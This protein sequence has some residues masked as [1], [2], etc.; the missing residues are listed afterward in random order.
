MALYRHPFPHEQTD[1]EILS[2]PKLRSQAI[3]K[4]RT[5][6]CKKTPPSS[7][8]KLTRETLPLIETYRLKLNQQTLPLT[9]T[10][11]LK[12]N[13]Q[14]LPLTETYRL[15]LNRETLPLT[16][17]YRL[18]LNRETLSPTE[19]IR[20]KLNQETELK[21]INCLSVSDWIPLQLI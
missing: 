14:T 18:K 9:E 16:E 4:S 11:R 12:L 8:L 17:A 19:A 1:V 5:G 21:Q 20:L 13:Q 2:H 15:K 6:D 7:E 3:I 10:Y